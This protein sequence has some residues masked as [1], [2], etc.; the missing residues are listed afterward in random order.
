MKTTG[1]AALV[2]LLLAGTLTDLAAN[3]LQRTRVAPQWTVDLGSGWFIPTEDGLDDRYKHGYN[4]RLALTYQVR[5]GFQFGANYRISTKEAFYAPGELDHTSHWLGLRLGYD[6]ARRWDMEV[7]LGGNLYLV[8]A[9]LDGRQRQCASD[10]N[11][12]SFITT[13]DSEGGYGMGASFV[14]AYQVNEIFGVGF[15]FE[16]NY[17]N[18]DYPTGPP[19]IADSNYN[20]EYYYFDNIGGIWLAPFIRLRF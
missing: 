2:L 7:S 13:E 12:S 6:L 17:S 11:C 10:P 16:Y 8:W 4:G 14:Y 18:L 20:L 3:P 19:I 15:E 9:K 5:S 1:I